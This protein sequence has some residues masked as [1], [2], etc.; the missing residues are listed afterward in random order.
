M[1][2]KAIT[3]GIAA[4]L[5]LACLYK[6]F[7]KKV[8]GNDIPGPNSYPLIG[9]PMLIRYLAAKKIHEYRNIMRLQFGDIYKS[10]LFGRE[11]ISISDADMAKIVLTDKKF[12]RG[13][14]DNNVTAGLLDFAL[15]ILPT[16]ELWHVHRKLL[17][18]AFGPSHLRDAAEKSVSV[19]LD[20]VKIWERKCEGKETVVIDIHEALTAATL[21]VIG[22]IAF[23]VNLNIIKGKE[24]DSIWATLG[25]STFGRVVQRVPIPQFL[26]NFY[27]IG[28]NSK[29]VVEAREKL[30]EY[31]RNL[32]EHERQNPTENSEKGM[33]VLQRLVQTD[34]LTDPEI[35]GE[36][37]GFFL[38]G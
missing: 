14:I 5:I 24:K 22:F 1:K 34:K 38:A 23:G 32:V 8:P 30:H 10:S 29:A 12:T 9:H 25:E 7:N 2:S 21:D 17:Q 33:N 20:L 3:A 16:G 19:S 27:G 28:P 4:G 13:E 15:F 6:Y 18:P 11:A 36:M 31:M 37:V 26:W 35:F